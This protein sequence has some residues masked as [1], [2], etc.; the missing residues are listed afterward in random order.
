[1]RLQTY[2]L[3]CFVPAM[4]A[5]TSSMPWPEETFG[6]PGG[7]VKTVKVTPPLDSCAPDAYINGY[8]YGY[9]MAWNQAITKN[10]EIADAALRQNPHDSAAQANRRLYQAKLFNLGNINQV[11]NRFDYVPPSVAC[12]STSYVQGRGQGE[13]D[14]I[15]DVAA[16][17]ATETQ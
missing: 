13:K 15:R 5:C 11:E 17:R 6:S 3:L 12:E 16:L 2:I 9:M 1:M 10:L 4:L 7:Y 8:R 14:A